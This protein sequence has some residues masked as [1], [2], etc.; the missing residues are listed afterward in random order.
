MLEYI[1]ITVERYAELLEAEELLSALQ[2][3]GVDNWEGYS[4]AITLMEGADD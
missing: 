4:E 3:V 1:S 2:A